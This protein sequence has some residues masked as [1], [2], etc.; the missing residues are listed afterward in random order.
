MAFL[1]L[2]MSQPRIAAADDWQYEATFYLHAAGMEGDAG[3]HGVTTD[4]DTSFRDILDHLDGGFMGMI[5]ARKGPWSLG[6]DVVYMNLEADESKSVT[7]PFGKVAVKGALDMETSLYVAMA[8]VGYRLLDDRTKFDVL[9]GLRY[10]RLEADADIKVVLPGVVFP[11]GSRSASGHDDWVDGV[12]GMRVIHP[13]AD[14]VSLV[15]Y[16]DV[17]AGGSDLT[18]QAIAGANWEFAEGYKAHAGY[19]LIYWD[20]D[21]DGNVWDITASGPYMGLG[22]SF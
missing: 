9:G 21:N 6:F 22:I 20:Y 3:I 12:V 18:Y 13:V 5:S 19:R 11:G 14:R 17:G 7:G 16:L 10:T 15:G 1:G 8:S 4:V 2:A